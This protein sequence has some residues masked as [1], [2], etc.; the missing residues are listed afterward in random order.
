MNNL[1]VAENLVLHHGPGAAELSTGDCSV[2][3][4]AEE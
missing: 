1:L 4:Y 3:L 2:Q